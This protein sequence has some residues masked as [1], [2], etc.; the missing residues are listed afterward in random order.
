MRGVRTSAL[1]MTLRLA[2]AA[3]AFATI[4]R[5]LDRDAR[6]GGTLL[7]TAMTTVTSIAAP[8]AATLFAH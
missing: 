8:T 4:P 2:V 6:T 5:R 3:R 7:G 1:R